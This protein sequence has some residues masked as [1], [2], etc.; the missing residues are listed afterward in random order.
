MTGKPI[1]R[2]LLSI[3]MIIEVSSVQRRVENLNSVIAFG[4]LGV[5]DVNPD[6]DFANRSMSF[7]QNWVL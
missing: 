4:F 3:I 6:I 7:L 5:F 2:L 1:Q